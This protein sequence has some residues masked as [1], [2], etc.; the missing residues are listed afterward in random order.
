MFWPKGRCLVYN[1]TSLPNLLIIFPNFLHNTSYATWTT[2]SLNCRHHAMCVHISHWPYGYP[3]FTSCSWQQTH[4][5]PWCNLQHL[6]CHCTKCWFPRGTRTITYVSFNHIQLLS[7]MSW[8]CAYQRWHSHLNRH[9][10]C[11]PN[12]NIFT[13]L[14][15]RNSRICYIKCNSS[16]GKELSQS[17]PHWS[18][19]PLSNWGVWL[20]T[21]TWICVL[22][23]LCQCHL[24]LEGD[25][26]PHL[27]T[28]VI[29]LRQKVSV[30]L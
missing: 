25:K 19:P 28:L 11:R 12:A 30:T 3:L 1:L 9:C 13:S 29:F 26:S 17:T 5:N 8:H 15:L 10:C 23:W 6:C 27:L 18:I 16:Q 24:E 21:Q 7:L 4:E 2:P 14:I 22:T 20:L